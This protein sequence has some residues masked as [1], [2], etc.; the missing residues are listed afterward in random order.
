MTTH[1][2]FAMHEPYL[3]LAATAVDG[4][5]TISTED[6]MAATLEVAVAAGSAGLGKY[7][8][9]IGNALAPSAFQTVFRRPAT[10]K[11]IKWLVDRFVN[12][13]SAN[14]GY[15]AKRLTGLDKDQSWNFWLTVMAPMVGE[16]PVELTKEQ[17]LNK[18]WSTK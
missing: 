8:E 2:A 16:A 5:Q 13:V 14:S 1:D 7:A 3:E 11:E 12:Y 10:E 9:G 18:T 15:L 17:S 4:K 6:V